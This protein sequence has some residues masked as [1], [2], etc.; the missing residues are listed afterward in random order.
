MSL[1]NLE[2]LFGSLWKSIIAF[3]HPNV[4]EIHVTSLKLLR[5]VDILIDALIWRW[6][7][8]IV[9]N[10]TLIALAVINVVLIIE[11]V[12]NLLDS[13]RVIRD[14][15]RHSTTYIIPRAALNIWVVALVSALVILI[16]VISLISILVRASDV[17]AEVVV[18]I[19]VVNDIL[20]WEI[21]IIAVVLR[22]AEIHL[23]VAIVSPDVVIW[24]IRIVVIRHEGV[25]HACH[26]LN[27]LRENIINVCLFADHLQPC[28]DDLFLGDFNAELFND[29][30]VD[31]LR[32]VAARVEDVL[33]PVLYLD[34]IPEH[35]Q[36]IDF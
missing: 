30:D 26:R 14:A 27:F 15:I 20:S 32:L 11:G 4:W 22:D 29:V 36:L 35:V 31:E 18:R 2:F 28:Y 13:S 34:V 5:L 9:I 23:L 1:N 3:I 25:D 16:H 8:C 19:V 12:G 33:F 7:V 17:Q 21:I 6:I 24:V 10:T